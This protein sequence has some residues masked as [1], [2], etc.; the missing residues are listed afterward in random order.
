MAK[1]KWSWLSKIVPTKEELEQW[2]IGWFDDLNNWDWK[3]WER[4]WLD[5]VVSGK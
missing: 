2:P 4:D 5:P 3:A 1:N